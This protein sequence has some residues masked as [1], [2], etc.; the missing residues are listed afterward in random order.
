MHKLP[1]PRKILIISPGIEDSGMRGL[2]RVTFSLIDGLHE[3]GYT[4]I[5]LTGAPI[6][7]TRRQ[8]L[9]E[10]LAQK[11][12]LSHYLSEGIKSPA[13]KLSRLKVLRAF[14]RD[15]LRLFLK[16]KNYI[17]NRQKISAQ[18]EPANVRLFGAVDIFVNFTLAYKIFAKLPNS[19]RSAYIFAIAKSVGADAVITA[20]PYP[21]KHTTRATKKIKIVQSLHDIMPL[22]ILETPP[23]SIDSFGR[24]FT[25]A[26][27]AADLV[28]TSSENAKNKLLSIFPSV[29]V[30][31]IYVPSEPVSNQNL[32]NKN[33]ARL[34]TKID[35]K[36]FLFMSALEKRKN[37]SRLLEAFDLV[38]PKLGY[39]LVL[40]GSKGY[41]YEEI[42]YSLGKMNEKSRK[43]AVKQRE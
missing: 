11:R 8:T 20:S 4:T 35:G 43:N 30:S 16:K 18:H 33:L 9:V 12:Y 1:Q 5:L 28:I 19:I 29:N 17:E 6:S 37:V 21:I 27:Q 23:D 39:K 15:S 31:A 3:L 38:D 2:G 26:M 24:S 42:E 34:Y 36:Y 40:V 7:I 10:Q 13:F 32:K 22:N 14:T 25:T 41:G